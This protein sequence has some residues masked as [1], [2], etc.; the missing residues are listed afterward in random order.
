MG[1]EE[2]RDI[3]AAIQEHGLPWTVGETELTRLPPEERRNYLGLIVT[4]EEHQ[5]MAEEFQRL[6]AQER[7]LAAAAPF[8]APAS[9]DWRNRNGQNYV[10]PVKNQGGCGSCV[11][12]CTC[13]VIE[14]AIRI[15]LGNP[16]Y[17]VDLSEGFL[18]FCGGGSCGGWGLTSGLA[19]A[20]ST[21]VT[22][23]ACMPYQATNMNCTA[24]RCAD[25]QNRLTK[26]SSYT[27][28]AGVDARKNAIATIGPV[29]SGMAVY[30]D[31]F[32]YSSGVYVK[33]PT[34][35]S[36]KLEGYHCICCV[37]YDDAQQAWIVKNSWGPNWGQGGFGLIRYG[38][39][40]LLIDTQ[41]MMYSVAGVAIPTTWY[42]NVPVVQTYASRDAANGWAFFQNLGWRRIQ[43]SASDGVT[44]ML[45]LFG[46]AKAGN[47]PVSIYADAQY[48]YQ[49]Y[50]S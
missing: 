42:W 40:D 27:G 33:S 7:T 11:S 24:S 13:S 12:F 20:Q 29:V 14:S 32:A 17:A 23:E 34:T 9:A 48:V 28:Y 25:W 35:A 31:F 45:S 10:T 49:G 18:Q 26:I 16:T 6:A 36:N 4:P 1:T 43:P 37:G 15:T 44:N 22:D 50:M 41:W 46:Q 38:Q 19:F 39:S 8:G 47:R 21:G 30:T 5:R 2:I 3:A